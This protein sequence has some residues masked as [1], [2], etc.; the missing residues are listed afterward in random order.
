[1]N[2]STILRFSP[3]FALLAIALP[4]TSLAA[5]GPALHSDSM[6]S[7]IS[8]LDV[9]MGSR[10][11]MTDQF[12]FEYGDPDFTGRDRDC[13]RQR[14]QDDDGER[15]YRQVGVVPEPSSIALTCAGIAAL[16]TA[17]IVRDRLLRKS[18][19]LNRDTA[20]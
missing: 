13:R 14:E 3:L 6:S 18:R 16:L 15:C 1:M 17:R 8:G 5:S 4:A 12:R 19:S 11:F 2:P 7:G 9:P 10:P 20:S